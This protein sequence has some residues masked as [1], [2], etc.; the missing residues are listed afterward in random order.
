MR[1]CLL[2]AAIA[3]MSFAASASAEPVKAPVRNANQPAGQGV[4]VVVAAAD[5]I[6]TPATAEQKAEA[7]A[8]RERKA[9]VTTCRCGDQT[10]NE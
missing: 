1:A 9:R 3:G 7:P 10:P 5:D 8:K 4:T 6:R 2:I